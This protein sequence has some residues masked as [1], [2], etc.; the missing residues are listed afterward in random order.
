MHFILIIL[1]EYSKFTKKIFLPN[2]A[3]SQKKASNLVIFLKYC[4]LDKTKGPKSG[5]E[6][7][8]PKISLHQMKMWPLHVSFM[9][10]LFSQDVA[11]FQNG[12]FFLGPTAGNSNFWVNYLKLETR[13]HPNDGI[14]EHSL[15]IPFI[16]SKQIFGHL[17]LIWD[18]SLGKR[19]KN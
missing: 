19:K 16:I 5:L 4:I 7:K 10:A 8:N 15:S 3:V 18:I 17:L 11:D 9:P 14:F 6:P 13:V 2:L 1:M 12:W